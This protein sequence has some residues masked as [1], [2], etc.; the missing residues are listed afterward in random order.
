[1]T[2]RLIARRRYRSFTESG[3]VAS[4]HQDRRTYPM[5]CKTLIATL[6]AAFT[7]FAA[8]CDTPTRTQPPTVPAATSPV[9]EPGAG[10]A[11]ARKPAALS[12]TP[13]PVTTVG[14]PAE[15]FTW[16]NGEAEL[17][18]LYTTR[19]REIVAVLRAQ[20]VRDAELSALTTTLAGVQEA[21]LTRF[22]EI[23]EAFPIE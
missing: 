10:P 18:N 20:G 3:P 13:G 16:E 4:P 6:A 22:R 17:R 11:T 21:G 15:S 5:F 23:A 14:A 1:M 12:A 9:L 7:A 8:G 19:F 2:D